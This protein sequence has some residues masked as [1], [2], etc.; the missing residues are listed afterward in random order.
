MKS[1][2]KLCCMGLS[3]LI[4]LC[5]TF[6]PSRAGAF[7]NYPDW[8]AGTPVARVSGPPTTDAAASDTMRSCT[9]QTVQVHGYERTAL[10]VTQMKNWRYALYTYFTHD[11]SGTLSHTLFVISIGADRGFYPVDGVS[12]SSQILEAPGT[13]TLVFY[14]PHSN[15][16]IYR[17]FLGFIE[18]S[19]DRY[20]LKDAPAALVTYRDGSRV[21]ANSAAVSPGGGW[22]VAGTDN[23]VIRTDIETV[24][25]RIVSPVVAGSTWEYSSLMSLA[26]S[27]DGQSVAIG[28]YMKSRPTF[29]IVTVNDTC[30]T[31]EEEADTAENACPAVELE[32]FLSDGRLP[33]GWPVNLRFTTHGRRLDF[34]VDEGSGSFVQAALYPAGSV[35]VALDYLALGDSFSSGEGDPGKDASGVPYY[36]PQTNRPGGP[37]TPREMCH[38]SR[39]SYPFRLAA[40][41]GLPAPPL[42]HAVESIACNNAHIADVA[43]GDPNGYLGQDGRLA[44]LGT[45]ELADLRSAAVDQFIPGRVRQADFVETYQPQ[46]ITL[47]IGGNDVQFAGVIRACATSVITCSYAGDPTDRRNLG[48]SIRALYPKLTDL[49]A[50]LARLDP[51]AK[52][53]AVGYSRFVNEENALCPANVNLDFAERHMIDQGVRYINQVIRAAAASAGVGYLDIEDALSGHRLCDVGVPYVNPIDFA[54]INAQEAFHP[55]AEAHAAIAAAIEHQLGTGNISDT[56]YCPAAAPCPVATD[57]PALPSFFGD[58]AVRPTYFALPAEL[59]VLSG[60]PVPY[61]VVKGIEFTIQTS[62]LAAGGIARIELHTDPLDL[63]TATVGVDGKLAI[64]LTLPDS[65]PPGF[66]TLHVYGTSPSGEAVDLYQILYISDQS[67]GSQGT[68]PEPARESAPPQSSSSP[69]TAGGSACSPK[70]TNGTPSSVIANAG[71]ILPATVGRFWPVAIAGA[72]VV[73][74]VLFRTARTLLR[75]RR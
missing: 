44:G 68:P 13:D 69:Q 49:F 39:R 2:F 19:G 50:H 71:T 27:D 32:P 72:G 48:E 57:P 60:S 46:A 35:P 31:G 52:L 17:N 42:G 25:T 18:R 6:L 73:A 28:G 63:G 75:H 16:W 67:E 62:L 38:L 37:G 51:S 74:L 24:E 55:T 33:R 8:Q 14:Q 10:C 43:S 53:Y 4:L 40:L 5:L 41:A 23:G 22:L 21:V 58:D 12:T 9:N 65:V 34:F 54:N 1:F 56:R 30:G 11:W 70:C 66:H 3:A 15:V 20:E 64:T 47:G 26:V 61:F 45:A 7:D 59:L 29:E 36:V